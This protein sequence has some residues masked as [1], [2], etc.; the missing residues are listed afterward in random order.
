MTPTSRAFSFHRLA[1]ELSEALLATYNQGTGEPLKALI[2]EQKEERDKARVA[3][4]KERMRLAGPKLWAAWHKRAKKAVTI[5]KAEEDKYIAELTAA[6][7]CGEC[8]NDFLELIAAH[9]PNY[10]DY[11]AYTVAI[12][13]A[14]NKKLGYK[15]MSLKDATA[16]YASNP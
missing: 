9:E 5:S 8:R 13:N 1:I 11:F 4:L 12:H 16:L 14:V 3:R 7:P 2:R 10:G 15:E 6:L